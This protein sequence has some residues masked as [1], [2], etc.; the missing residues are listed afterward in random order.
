LTKIFI[1]NVFKKIVNIFENDF[2][3]YMCG[4]PLGRTTNKARFIKANA[5]IEKPLANNNHVISLDFTNR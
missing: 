3:I 4:R 2:Y 1:T 5:G